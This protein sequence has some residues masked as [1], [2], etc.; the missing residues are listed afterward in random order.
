MNLAAKSGGLRQ[1]VTPEGLPLPLHLAS[2]TA[3]IGAFALDLLILTALTV[4][5]ALSLYLM[6]G[7]MGLDGARLFLAIFLFVRFFL[8]NGYFLFFELRWQGASPGK[9]HTGVRVVSR[10]GGPLTPGAVVARNLMRELEFYLPLQGLLAPQL[11]YGD[12]P[13]WALVIASSWLLV[14]LLMP[15]TNRDRA[16]VGDLVAGTLVVVRPEA[17]LLPDV[18]LATA[19]A[20]APAAFSP[21][22]GALAF[23]AEQLDMYGI[24]ELQVLERVLREADDR[25][26]RDD[27]LRLICD[28]IC[29]KIAWP[30]AVPDRGVRPFLDLFYQ[31]QRQRLEQR[32][33]MGERRESKR[34]GR[35]G[36]RGR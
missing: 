18:A 7:L 34:R 36:G 15:L 1:I 19:A 4:L 22:A 11:I 14:F 30:E 17:R 29:Q 16:R 13:G 12:A 6:A 21:A 28:R 2:L 5:L 3:R 10:D 20:P 27:L 26:D 9:K 23:T 32:L 25:E 31:A 35:L 8:W 24:K 33:L